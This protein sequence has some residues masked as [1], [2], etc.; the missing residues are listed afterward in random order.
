MKEFEFSEEDLKEELQ[1]EH[2]KDNLVL[3]DKISELI[4]MVSKHLS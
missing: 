1:K 3:E 2:H 4:N